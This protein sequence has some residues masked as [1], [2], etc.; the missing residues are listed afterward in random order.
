MTDRLVTVPASTATR[1]DFDMLTALFGRP[2]PDGPKQA[3]LK[4]AEQE[5]HDAIQAAYRLTKLA[6]VV[7]AKA[8][9]EAAYA[10]R[11]AEIEEQALR[12][13]IER[14]LRFTIELQKP[15]RAA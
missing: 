2:T 12:E 9:A 8:A 6:D 4:E 7:D 10:A 13:G 1:G 11:V 3:E 5:R 15:R 14:D